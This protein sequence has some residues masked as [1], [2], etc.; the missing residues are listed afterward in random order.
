M[1]DPSREGDFR[2][3]KGEI[4]SIVCILYIVYT[5]YAPE[6]HLKECLTSNPVIFRSIDLWIYDT[7]YVISTEGITTRP[8]N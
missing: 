5:L 7:I 3:N 1:I 4:V 2:G 8:T 6:L